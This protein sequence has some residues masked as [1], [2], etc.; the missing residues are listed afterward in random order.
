MDIYFIYGL[1]NG[2]RWIPANILCPR[3]AN[4]VF[5]DNTEFINQITIDYLK[6]FFV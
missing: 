6:V 3:S 1:A 4:Y 5:V 2:S